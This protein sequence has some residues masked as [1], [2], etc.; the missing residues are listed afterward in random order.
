MRWEPALASRTRRLRPVSPGQHAALGRWSRM[1]ALVRPAV[2]E[3]RCGEANRRNCLHFAPS[4][5]IRAR[6]TLGV[7]AP[8]PSAPMDGEGRHGRFDRL[9]AK[10]RPALLSQAMRFCRGD[11]AVA[12]DL[13]QETF[14]RAWSR[15]DSL[16]DEAKALAWLARI[17]RNHWID[18]CRSRAGDIPVADVPDQSVPSE[19]P[20]LWEDLTSEDLRR[21]ID[22][23]A[24]P[25]RSTVILRDVDGLSNKDIAQRLAIP[26]PTVATR[27]HRAHQQLQ[28]LLKRGLVE[29]KRA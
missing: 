14:L 3:V 22:Q 7:G 8:H 24:E 12:E 13:V 23:L 28:E 18:R 1:T 15:F 17:L 2:R 25:Y 21:A 27:L 16:G 26:Y 10:H 4:R 6:L 9:T 11:K 29:R 20:S 19:E 5:R